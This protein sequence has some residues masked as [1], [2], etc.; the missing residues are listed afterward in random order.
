VTTY[1][2]LFQ[3]A[4]T[5]YMPLQQSFF[6]ELW[7]NGAMDRWLG[8]G[9]PP[10]YQ[11]RLSEPTAV[12]DGY[13]V[14]DIPLVTDAVLEENGSFTD[15]TAGYYPQHSSSH[16]NSQGIPVGGNECYMDGHVAW[17][18]FGNPGNI[19]LLN[20]PGQMKWRCEQGS[21]TPWFIW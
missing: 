7:S 20:A 21:G 11:A 14:A 5:E 19:K 2:W 3:R 6:G 18:P 1:F 12:D 15:I 10:A 13:N 4:P 9:P 17:I 8:Q 16:L